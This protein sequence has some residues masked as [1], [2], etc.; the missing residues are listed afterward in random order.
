MWQTMWP[1]TCSDWCKYCIGSG[2]N[3]RTQ[4]VM[5]WVNSL[6]TL[7]VV[8]SCL[9]NREID[10]YE[11]MQMITLLITHFIM[12]WSNSVRYA[13]TDAAPGG[14]VLSLQE[15]LQVAHLQ[16]C[17]GLPRQGPCGQHPARRAHVAA[18]APEA[19]AAVK[20][21]ALAAR[22]LP[23]EYAELHAAALARH[24]TAPASLRYHL[25]YSAPHIP[26]F[27]LR[28]IHI[29]QSRGHYYIYYFF[30]NDWRTFDIFVT[31]YLCKKSKHMNDTPAIMKTTLLFAQYLTNLISAVFFMEL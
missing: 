19:T 29:T 26:L 25:A 5:Q 11:F 18:A 4:Q 31:Y 24:L 7:A 16:V 12:W 28:H 27:Q 1:M 20:P 21:L 17:N 8:Q 14:D 30:Y 13:R 15:A 22:P 2:F 3:N 6:S 23:L 10:V 9:N